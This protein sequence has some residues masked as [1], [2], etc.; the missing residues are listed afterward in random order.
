MTRPNIQVD[1]EVR[2]MTEQEYADLLTTG[3]AL[4]PSDEVPTIGV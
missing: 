4:E 3:W 1:D 2:E